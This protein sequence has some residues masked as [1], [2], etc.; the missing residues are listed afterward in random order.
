[1]ELGVAEPRNF[2]S[3]SL[4]ER[5]RAQ[6]SVTLESH[7][8]GSAVM[9]CISPRNPWPPLHL[10]FVEQGQLCQDSSTQHRQSQ[11]GFCRPNPTSM[12]WLGCFRDNCLAN[13]SDI[14]LSQAVPHLRLMMVVYKHSHNSSPIKV[15][16]WFS[17]Y[18]L[19]DKA[20]T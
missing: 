12:L 1:M 19:Y 3:C 13:K 15:I 16:K 6:H 10:L 4:N 5:Q 14:W 8:P 20:G 18:H 2:L 17:V 7:F 9:S 11:T